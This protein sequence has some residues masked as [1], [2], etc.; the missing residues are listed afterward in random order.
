MAWGPHTHKGE[1]THTQP[2]TA[3]ESADA[4]HS[5][6]LPNL[7][8]ALLL[9]N[10]PSG[11]EAVITLTRAGILGKEWFLMT[12]EFC[13]FIA[14]LNSGLP[15]VEGKVWTSQGFRRCCAHCQGDLPG[16]GSQV[17]QATHALP[18]RGDILWSL[19]SPFL[20]PRL[21]GST[22]EQKGCSFKAVSRDPQAPHSEFRALDNTLR[23]EVVFPLLR[24]LCA[25]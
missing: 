7:A 22:A 5:S 1:D 11:M 21:Q 23:I 9:S 12:L 10:T 14:F 6:F 20:H 25:F 24:W 8:L 4:V 16:G 15:W 2:T 18:T 13:D 19:L 17:A 3:A